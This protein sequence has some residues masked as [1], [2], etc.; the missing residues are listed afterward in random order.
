MAEGWIMLHRRLADNELWNKKPFSQGQAWV[1]LLMLANWQDGTVVIG[2]QPIECKRGQSVRSLETYAKRWGWSK[3][4]VRRFFDLLQKLSMIRS[5]NVTKTTR[6]TICKYESYQDFGND[7][8]TILKR[9]RNDSET[10]LAPNEQSN[11][12]TREEEE[13]HTPEPKPEPKPKAKK[14]SY[15][16]HVRMTEEEHSKLVNEYGEADTQKFIERLNTYK[17][18]TGKT[19][20][21]DYMT[22]FSWVI[23]AVQKDQQPN[24]PNGKSNGR[25]YSPNPAEYEQLARELGIAG[26]ITAPN[27]VSNA[28]VC[29]VRSGGGSVD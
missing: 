3:S 16:E 26:P 13:I 11:K 15:A 19:Y 18:S 28:T 21:S 20:K 23:K 6:I 29:E 12:V 1:D 4:A 5:E 27:D 22:M 2:M 24:K 10:I 17:G 9:S 8:E 7:S 14:I 25:T